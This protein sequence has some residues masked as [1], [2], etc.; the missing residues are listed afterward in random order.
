MHESPLAEHAPVTAF[1]E[2]DVEPVD[3]RELLRRL[4]GSRAVAAQPGFIDA[5]FYASADGRTVINVARW[6]SVTA[7]AAFR[8]SDAADEQAR[9]L[10]PFVAAR[11]YLCRA[12]GVLLHDS[13]D[14]GPEGDR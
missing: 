3:T 13:A 8:A 6:S 9:M 1:I 5:H 14:D 11:S 4:R 10:E 7:L 2:F 12:A